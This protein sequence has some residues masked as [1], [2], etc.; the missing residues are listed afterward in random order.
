M[1]NT[2]LLGF[3]NLVSCICALPFSCK[4]VYW[5]FV[6]FDS[7]TVLFSSENSFLEVLIE[8]IVMVGVCF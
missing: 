7:C 1:G 2:L 3:Y 4:S 6:C 5:P 8:G